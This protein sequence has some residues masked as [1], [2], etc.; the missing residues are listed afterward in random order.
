ML[1][2]PHPLVTAIPAHMSSMR[3]MQV[4]STTAQQA[5]EQA[6]AVA[7]CPCP[8]VSPIA[9]AFTDSRHLPLPEFF[10]YSQIGFL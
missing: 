9:Q 2:F 1:I 10:A 8:C 3:G 4:K 5:N 6:T 7:R